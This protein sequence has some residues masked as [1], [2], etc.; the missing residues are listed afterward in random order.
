MLEKLGVGGQSFA[1]TA[2]D[3]ENRFNV[4]NVLYQFSH[5]S[6]MKI[7]QGQKSPIASP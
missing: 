3:P 5:L 2:L 1:P 7:L 4:T 6:K